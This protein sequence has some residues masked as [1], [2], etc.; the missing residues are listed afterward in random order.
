MLLNLRANDRLPSGLGFAFGPQFTSKQKAN[1]EGTLTIPSQY[2]INA[3]VF[4][5]TKSWDLQV[6]VD[7]VTNRNNWTV[8]DPE[9]TRNTVIY[10]ETP[11]TPQLLHALP[12][13]STSR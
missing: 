13:P 7:N 8:G 2:K 10:Q 9:F 5:T 3:R 4:Y 11:L 12:V 1:G 6:N